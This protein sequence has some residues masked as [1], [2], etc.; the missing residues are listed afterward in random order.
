ME[1][2]FNLLLT[3]LLELP[4]VGFFFRKRKRKAALIVA[5]FLNVITWPLV[6]IIRLNT[7]WN[8]DIVEIFVVLLEGAGYWMVLSIGW[9]KGFFIS[10][11]ANIASF[12]IT[13]F[14]YLKPE[15]FQKN[16]DII[17]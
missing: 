14:V 1:L 6:N 5:L 11:I 16:I 3:I 4:I 13:K 15:F 8:L 7:S 9:K 12:V 10:L 17:R 2:A